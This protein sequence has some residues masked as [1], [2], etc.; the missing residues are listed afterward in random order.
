[1]YVIQLNFSDNKSQAK[2]LM[3]AH[4]VWLQ[5]GF[6]N[7]VFIL[8]GS[9]ESGKGGAIIAHNCT[10]AEIT[11][12]VEQDPFAQHNVVKAEITGIAPSKTDPRLAFLAA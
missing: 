5:Q 3:P 8:A 4:N 9:I 7:D 12:Y 1:M 11:A 2:A 10:L 6:E